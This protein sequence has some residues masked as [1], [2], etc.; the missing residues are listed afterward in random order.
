MGGS[1]GVEFIS[2][3]NWR[4][5]RVFCIGASYYRYNV[6]A[7]QTASWAI[8]TSP[9]S[10]V[11]YTSQTN[12]TALYN[13]A[14]VDFS[15]RNYVRVIESQTQRLGAGAGVTLS[16]NVYNNAPTSN[17]ADENIP[18]MCLFI[19]GNLCYDLA[20]ET[21]EMISIE[22]YYNYEIRSVAST[23]PRLASYGLKLSLLFN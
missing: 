7:T 5:Y 11:Y 1:G 14:M 4:W 20:I 10:P 19:S 12:Y 18:I 8:Y 17:F 16:P 21:D 2:K 3:E 23:Y 15:F 13:Y 6:S 9:T 22:P